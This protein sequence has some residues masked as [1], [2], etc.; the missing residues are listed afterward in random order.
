M[1]RVVTINGSPRRD[2]NTGGMLAAAE[3]E[4][5]REGI[6]VERISLADVDVRPCIACE[7]CHENPWN[8]LSDQKIPLKLVC[9]GACGVGTPFCLEKF[10]QF[11]STLREF[12]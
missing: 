5:K 2:G 8:C 4:L 12:H 9:D 7:E 1:A 10:S 3:E 6:E 11:C